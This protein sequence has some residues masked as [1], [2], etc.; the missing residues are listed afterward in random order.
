[1]RLRP[2]SLKSVIV[3]LIFFTT[4]LPL[5]IIIPWLSNQ[6]YSAQRNTHLNLQN[7]QNRHIQSYIES[8]IK[9]IQSVLINKTDPLTYLLASK[10]IDQERINLLLNKI[11]FRE[12][13]V[14]STLLIDT[15]GNFIAGYDRH[16]PKI[17]E[18][19]KQALLQ[20]F[21]PK[22]QFKGSPFINIPLYGRNYISG[23]SK[24]E[25]HQ[26]ASTFTI[27]TPV[28]DKQ[29]NTIAILLS[30]IEPTTLWQSI[31]NKI[32]PSAS[33]HYLI[34][35]HG[36]YIHNSKYFK[37]SEFATHFRIVQSLLRNK[38]WS[39]KQEYIGV[40]GQQVFGSSSLIPLVNWGVI[41]ET[42]VNRVVAPIKRNI[43]ILISLFIIFLTVLIFITLYSVQRAF[44]P[45]EHLTNAFIALGEG[46]YPHLAL[47]YFSELN[48]LESGFNTMVQKR[49]DSELL[50]KNSLAEIKQTQ[51]EL[52]LI[53]NTA[54]E[55]DALKHSILE[56]MGAGVITLNDEFKIL[57]IN[58]EAEHIFGYSNKNIYLLSF[59]TLLTEHFYSTINMP[60]NALPY[61]QLH[62]NDKRIETTGRHKTG[63]QFP[64]DLV[65]SVINTD[66]KQLY[67][68]I[69]RDISEQKLAQ[70]KLIVAKETAEMANI[71]K[72]QFLSSM[73]HELR[74]PLNAILGFSQLIHDDENLTSE[75]Q[76]NINEIY[77]AGEHLLELINN[78]L[79]LAT[80]ESGK[81]SI[82]MD[83]VNFMD[84]LL[85]S[86]NILRTSLSKK[87]IQLNYD[88]ETVKRIQVTADAFRLKQ[89]MLNLL[90]NAIK[91]NVDS[92]TITI[93]CEQTPINTWRIE[94]TDTGRGIAEDKLKQLFT[95]FNRLGSENTTI[96]GT[97][98]GLVIT[99]SLMELMQG[100]IG[101]NSQLNE[102][103]TFWIELKSSETNN[104]MLNKQV[105]RDKFKQHS[106]TIPKQTYTVLYADDN[107]VNRLI[108]KQILSTFKNINYISA[109]DGTIGLEKAK[110]H[111]PD[112][113]LL[114]IHMPNINGNE[115][116]QILKIQYP[117]IPVIAISAD[118]DK[119]SIE[120]AR[121]F[122]FDN[123]LTKPFNTNHLVKLINSQIEIFNKT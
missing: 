121:Q 8:E 12:A 37:Q 82:N 100:E 91:Y 21:F 118:A 59:S 43:T 41:S 53:T 62:N 67:I 78:V 75:Q 69:V 102:G 81:M 30:A 74:T 112:L 3:W 40:S 64:I 55:N 85:A 22:K 17:N 72:S 83:D 52:Q 47:S 5:L 33:F 120:K 15:H 105:S 26:H 68:V 13:S 39:S 51:S 27:A 11:L 19:H 48:V 87:S 24:H 63:Y 99:K 4:L 2:H 97:G 44:K 113:V 89:V 80:I 106:A 117:S 23:I 46:Q 122:G 92:G 94:V 25:V 77:I 111:S 109:E 50:L 84:V 35:R 108:V 115:L 16:F 1:M 93:N 103:T 31:L 76:D 61:T 123:Y 114:D 98:I 88:L 107:E 65:M 20:A 66:S 95:P 79:D 6:I 18:N 86:E 29:N 60:L 7:A 110:Q 42:P 101:V 45:L 38:T 34:D 58:S 32:T 90:S 116:C 28:I 70:Q 57:N 71:A 54:L 104:P 56:N 73:S 119:K 10:P 14:H 9:R 96:E 49:E 36:A